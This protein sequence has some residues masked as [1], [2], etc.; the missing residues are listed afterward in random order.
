MVVVVISYFEV[1]WSK[2]QLH[3][4]MIWMWKRERNATAFVK[5]QQRV[6][7]VFTILFK[8][9]PQFANQPPNSE[10][11]NARKDF[12]K[13]QRKPIVLIGFWEKEKTF[14][15][16]K[17]FQIRKMAVQWLL[18]CHGMMTLTVVISFLCGQWPIFKGTP[19]QWIHYFL[20]FGAYDYFLYY[21][22]SSDWFFL[23]S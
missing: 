23:C 7:L 4:Q 5:P 21:F 18:V 8:Y 16:R 1:A 22:F 19:F 14:D 11:V 10:T 20:T 3:Y 12:L 6:L 2:L 17:I 9:F 13:K 15:D